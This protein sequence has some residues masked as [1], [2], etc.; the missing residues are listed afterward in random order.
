MHRKN[1]LKIKQN[2]Q[3]RTGDIFRRE[4]IVCPDT[5]KRLIWNLS[6]K[7]ELSTVRPRGRFGIVFQVKILI[8]SSVSR[9]TSMLNSCMIFISVAHLG[10]NSIS[11]RQSGNCKKIMMSNPR[12]K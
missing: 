3:L 6:G 12:G 10:T 5:V 7:N 11:I 4:T 8:E 1:R 9:R 2:Y